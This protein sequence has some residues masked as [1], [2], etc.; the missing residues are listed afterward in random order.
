MN[1]KSLKVQNE[2]QKNEKTQKM[3]MKRSPSRGFGDK[4]GAKMCSESGRLGSPSPSKIDL[5]KN[6][7]IQIDF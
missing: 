4:K 5:V 1:K 2:S 6:L 7:S 3:K